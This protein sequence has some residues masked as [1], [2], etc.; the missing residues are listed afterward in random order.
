[1]LH[2]D[3]LGERA[4]LTPAKTALV[5]VAGGERLSYAELDRR[6]ERCAALWRSQGLAPGERVAVLAGNSVELLEAFFAAGKSGVVLV[7][8]NTRATAHE[9]RA[10]LEDCAAAALFYEAEHGATA[11]ALAEVAGVRLRVRF[12]AGEGGDPEYRRLLERVP[13][14][15]V[16]GPRPAP[17]DP[18]C[19]LYTSGTTGRPKG[20]VIPHRMVAWNAYNTVV[21]WQLRESDVSPVFTPLYHAGGLG[22]FLLPLFAV[23][24]TVVLHRGF[25]AAEV[26]AAIE[27]EGSTVILGVPTILQ[28]LAEAP[29][30]ETADLSRVRWLISGGAPLPRSVIETYHRRS[31]V[32]RQGYG[33]TEVGVNC[34]AMSDEEAYT[35][36]GSIGKPLMFTEVKLV[37]EAGAEVAAGEVGELCFRGPHVSSGYWGNPEATAKAYDGEGWFHT[38]DLAR[39]DEEGFFYIAGRRKEMFISGGVNIYPAEIESELLAHPELADAAVVGV[40]DERWGEV[41]VAFVVP[42]APPGPASEELAAYLEERLARYKVPKRFVVVDDLPRT[43]YGKVVKGELKKGARRLL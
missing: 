39:R 28:M 40:P 5:V 38:G 15:A 10:V 9:H 30:F 8:L 19:L 22:V 34:F 2:G 12:G 36:A 16:R 13:E 42:A 43:P 26:L 21:G 23:G 18:Y 14:E 35:K 32:L 27:R 33:L 24:G 11:A 6:A 4:R 7:P 37:D 1:M 3:V 20:V 25:D 17:E 41:G 29:G 31:L